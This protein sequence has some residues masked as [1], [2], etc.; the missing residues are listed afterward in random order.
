MVVEVAAQA[1]HVGT[2]NSPTASAEGN[3]RRP[4]IKFLERAFLAIPYLQNCF[5]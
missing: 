2:V 1:L 4:S 5:S 3:T